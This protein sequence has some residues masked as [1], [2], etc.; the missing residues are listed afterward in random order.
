MT[1]PKAAFPPPL[2]EEVE[3][4]LFLVCFLDLY[5]ETILWK[6]WRPFMAAVSSS[7]AEPVLL[8][9]VI[10][11]RRILLLMLLSS[12]VFSESVESVVYS[13]AHEESEQD[14]DNN[15]FEGGCGGRPGEVVEDDAPAFFW[16]ASEE[17]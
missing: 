8:L 6:G 2:T 15:K 9:L 5:F 14:E 3:V 1:F 10:L 16:R 7:S 4:L 12:S 11:E 13:D 17:M